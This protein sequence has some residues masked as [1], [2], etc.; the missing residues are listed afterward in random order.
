MPSF[1]LP[2]G[3]TGGETG[4]P[5]EPIPP[6]P[7]PRPVDQPRRICQRAILRSFLCLSLSLPSAFNGANIFFP[8]TSRASSARA[9]ARLD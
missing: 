2:P 6:S 3:E 7:P 1:L 8:L 4:H 5:S 9:R